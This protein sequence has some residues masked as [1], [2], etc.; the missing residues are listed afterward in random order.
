MA[1]LAGLSVF[2]VAEGGFW[3]CGLG[4]P[5]A[6]DDPFVGFSDL[7]PLFVHDADA[8]EFRIPKSRQKFFA[9]DA[10]PD[11][12]TAR[13]TRVFCLGGST[14]QGRPFSIETSFT[15]WLRLALETAQPDRGWEVINC[16]GISYASYRLVPI[17]QE[18]LHYQ[19]DLFILCTGHNEFLEDRTYGDIRD[20]PAVVAMPHQWLARTRSY[21]VYHRLLLGT[22]DDNQDGTTTI[23]KHDVETFLDYHNGLKAFRRDEVWRSGVIRHFEFNL[24][25]MLGIARDASVPV[26][27][28]RPPSNLG[29]TSP[30]KSE[31]RATESAAD[32]ETWEQ[33]T[34]E[35]RSLLAS[36]PQE[37]L[38]LFDEALLIH[39]E[40]AAT[41]FWR[42]K[43]LESL[44]R[45]DAAREAFVRARDED[46]CPLRILSPMERAIEKAA[47]RWDVPLLDAHELLERETRHGIL[48]NSMLVDHV[49][50]TFEG[51]QS[52]GLALLKVMQDLQLVEPQAD[53]LPQAKTAFA[54][55][56][57]SLPRI[58]FLRGERN[59]DGLRYWAQGLAD[60]PPIESG[61]PERVGDE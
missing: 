23:L 40:Y 57:D 58:Y 30:F 54:R 48:D 3:L 44:S 2:A 35:A 12:K 52:I 45:F 36:N 4:Q 22:N 49:H 14:V 43:L 47:R 9:A 56:F 29:D 5:D 50:P 55:H 13:T 18:C 11:E 31:L 60:G 51:H 59:L 27:L 42:G 33:L 53:W 10:F 15:T 34:A 25:R 19:P 61:F 37:S 8:H 21:H 41:H 28:I 38:R 39:D 7:Q 20:V 24:N 1:V 32:R 16:G 6:A 46:I 17:L 26:L